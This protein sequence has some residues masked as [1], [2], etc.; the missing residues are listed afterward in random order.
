MT[1]YHLKMKSG[2]QKTGPI[3]VSVTGAATCPDACPF[4]SGNGCYAEGGPMAIHW[5][6]V[7]RGERGKLLHEFLVDVRAIK[8]G[9]IWRHNA[10]GD[11]PGC[12]NEID[13]I[14]LAELTAANR[15]KR[16]FSYTHKPLTP[17]NA[18]AI[19]SANAGGF[20][21]NLSANNLAHADELSDA[22]VGPVVVVVP[23]SVDGAKTKTLVTP[24]GR[25]VTVCPATYRD[26]VTCESCGLCQRA[27]RKSIVAF[28]AHGA[29]KRKASAVAA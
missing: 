1:R 15:G 19:A 28:P 13:P 29:R 20:T 10:A 4:K 8:A 27:N 16:G 24:A 5:G 14:A 25:V 6:K 11:L 17:G 21:V 3:P 7:S 2:N 12:G 9:Q 26:D 18:A 23:S 22:N